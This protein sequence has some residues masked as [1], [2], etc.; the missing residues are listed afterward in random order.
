MLPP[1]L[2]TVLGYRGR[3]N[4]VA[5]GFGPD[6]R[7]WFDDGTGTTVGEPFVHGVFFHHPTV[8]A[9]ALTYGMRADDRTQRWLVD[10]I[11]GTIEFV[12]SDQAI[13]LVRSETN[14]I[15]GFNAQSVAPNAGADDTTRI[16]RM[17]TS[18]QQVAVAV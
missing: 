3:R 11:A 9:H 4:L 6:N 8:K 15:V 1:N 16:S 13:D 12:D 5:F 2:L 18:Q 17:L 7:L 14:V 10:Q